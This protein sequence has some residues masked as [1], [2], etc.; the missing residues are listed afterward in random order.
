ME[1]FNVGIFEFLLIAGLALVVFGP[2][3]LPEMGRFVGKQ[4]ARVLAWQQNSPE[5]KMLL[6]L[7]QEFEQEIV[8][9]RDDLVRTRQQLDISNE[10]KLIDEQTRS[11][12]SGKQ[13]L[14]IRPAGGQVTAAAAPNKLA[15]PAELATPNAP[16]AEPAELVSADGQPLH[17]APASAEPSS[18]NGVIVQ[19]EGQPWALPSEP[20]P[21]KVAAATHGVDTATQSAPADLEAA[22]RQLLLRQLQMLMVDMQALMAE[23]QERGVID[24]SWQPPSQSREETIAR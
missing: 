4:V 17:S 22:D 10:V 12:L 15:A 24:A 19:E 20:L 3:R 14:N 6:D 18:A 11:L 1:I 5:A 9:L 2:E 7:R 8:S 13:P 21:H 23:L 16:P